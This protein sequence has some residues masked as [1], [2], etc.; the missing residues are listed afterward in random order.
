MV[1]LI[2]VA[3]FVHDARTKGIIAI[4]TPQLDAA[5]SLLVDKD[6]LVMSSRCITPGVLKNATKGRVAAY[7]KGLAWPT[8]VKD[9]EIF[10]DPNRRAGEDPVALRAANVRYVLTD[11]A[12]NDDWTFPSTQA[13]V[14]LQKASYLKDGQPQ[15]LTLWWVEPA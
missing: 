6:D 10:T 13:V 8:D 12:C 3:G 1:G 14:P 2:D 5:R 7:N 9:F 11:S 15:E 4:Q